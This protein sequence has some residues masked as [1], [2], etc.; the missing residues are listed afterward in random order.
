MNF[1]GLWSSR[2]LLQDRR[3]N[4]ISLLHRVALLECIPQ[5]GLDEVFVQR[6]S[7]DD[8]VVYFAA[9]PDIDTDFINWFDIPQKKLVELVK[10]MAKRQKRLKSIPS[11]AAL[12]MTL[13]P[14]L[15]YN[16]PQCPP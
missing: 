10:Y 16:Q 8:I 5:S 13:A 6:L 1:S 3:Q 14:V 9:H 12:S 2:R 7:V 4:V 11:L 15:L